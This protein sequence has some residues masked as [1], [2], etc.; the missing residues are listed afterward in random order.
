MSELM[1]ATVNNQN[2]EAKSASVPDVLSE[3]G[4]KS[5]Y[6]QVWQIDITL[7]QDDDNEGRVLKFMFKKPSTASFNRYMKTA[8]KNMA[9]S[10]EV[11]VMDKIV[12]EQK[13]KLTKECE[14]YPGL[15]LNI[16]QKLLG[17]IGLGDNINFRKL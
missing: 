5:K 16:G 8:S 13:E 12:D 9:T 14:S 3:N 11:F 1:N 6:G 4:Y 7:D 10:T 15:A 17:V 2:T